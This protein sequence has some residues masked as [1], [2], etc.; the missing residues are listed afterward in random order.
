MSLEFPPFQLIQPIKKDM[1]RT[2]E[3]LKDYFEKLGMDYIEIFPTK[4]HPPIV[5][6]EKKNQ[7]CP[8]Q[9]PAHLRALRR[10]TT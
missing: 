2:A 1:E 4:V 9:K 10:T 6:A 8:T 3:F 7:P 5:F